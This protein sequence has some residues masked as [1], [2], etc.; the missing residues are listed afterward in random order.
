MRQFKFR[1]WNRD[2]KV[3]RYDIGLLP[4]NSNISIAH[5]ESGW[6]WNPSKHEVMQSTGLKDKNGK[7]IYEG[8][9]VEFDISERICRDS[10][11]IRAKVSFSMCEFNLKAISKFDTDN[12]GDY[13]HSC[14][15]N[16][17][18]SN[19]IKVIGNI[20]ENPELLEEKN[21]RFT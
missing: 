5:E 7:E 14:G 6:F 8:D 11:I 18:W 4:S 21:D 10:E 16:G 3:M 13:N 17:L 15:G 12:V 9:I 20:F 2:A 19:G 1:A